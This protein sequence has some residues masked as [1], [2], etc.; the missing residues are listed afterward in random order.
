MFNNKIPNYSFYIVLILIWLYTFYQ[1]VINPPFF[2]YYTVDENFIADSGVFLWYGITPRCLDWPAS[3]SLLLFFIPFGLHVVVNTLFSFDQLGNIID[4]FEGI[5]REAYQYLTQRT[6]YLLTGRTMQLIIIG[7]FLALTIRFTLKKDNSL[8]TSLSR[9]IFLILFV[10]AFPIWFNAPV[11]RP[12][13][14]SG[15]IFL[16]ILVRLIFTHEI[17]ESEVYL[18]AVLFGIILAER[19]LFVFVAPIVF[20]GIYIKT[21]QKKFIKA[22]EAILLTIVIFLAFCP[23]MLT[24]T[25]VIMKAFFGGIFAKMQDKPM[26]TFFNESYILDYL[27]SPIYFLTFFLVLVGGWT[28]LKRKNSFSILLIVNLILYLLMVLH[29]AKIYDTHVLPAGI[30][31]LGLIGFGITHIAQRLGKYKNYTAIILVLPIVFTNLYT[32]FD[33]HKSIHQTT[34]FQKAYTWVNTLPSD[35]KMLVHPTFEFFLSKN[36]ATLLRDLEQNRDSLKMAVKLN[37][38]MGRKGN[39]KDFSNLLPYVANAFAFEDERL[40]EIQYQLLLKYQNLSKESVYDYDVFFDSIE[41]TN[42]AIKTEIALSEYRKGKYEY[43]FTY[44]ILDGKEPYKVFS[45]EFGSPLFC[46]KSENYSD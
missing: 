35:T 16:Y 29:S 37:Y 44:E 6:D 8:L 23:F 3:P 13:A 32:L 21:P 22:S 36:K 43:L 19:L 18:F 46:Y 12:E 10:T 14:I 7:V 24:D 42:H 1:G 40:S 2:G 38:L 27:S 15:V 5:D 39:P 28:L 30:I 9:P 34:S 4:V 26:P 45:D 25:L 33:F 17:S 41:L 31:I 20:G 11:L